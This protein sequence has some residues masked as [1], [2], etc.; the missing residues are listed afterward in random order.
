MVKEIIKD[1]NI[2]KTVSVDATRKDMQ[3][4]RDLEDTLKANQEICVG[5]AA[6]MIGECKKIMCLYDN[7]KLITM[8]NPKIIGH[9][10][11]AYEVEEGCLSLEGVT[12][13]YRY[14][15]VTVKFFDKT[16]KAKT[17]TYSGFTAEIIQHEI[18]HFNGVLI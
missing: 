10:S 14:K 5:L 1:Q 15:T 9:S 16:W 7:T 11:E 17:I 2:L 3:V 18:D 13:T 12:K 4:V 8:I 6:N